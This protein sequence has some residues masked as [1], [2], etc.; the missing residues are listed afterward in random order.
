M[1]DWYPTQQAALI[2]WHDN[3]STQATI[4]GTLGPTA[5]NSVVSTVSTVP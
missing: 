2:A 4:N 1:A 5:P 3:F